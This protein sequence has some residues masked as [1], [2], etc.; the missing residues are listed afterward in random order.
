MES[1]SDFPRNWDFSAEPE[2]VG[3]YCEIREVAFPDG[4]RQLVELELDSGERVT[5]WLS[6]AA[7]RRNF[8]DELK[9]RARNGASDFE[10][11]ERI[12]IVRGASKRTS[13]NGFDYW[14]FT[15]EF[16]HAAK[17]SAADLLLGDE[18]QAG[19]ASQLSPD[20]DLPF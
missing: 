2:L 18:S 8:V 10:V 15:I 7:L 16:Q 9:A 20:D 4:S 19:D 1:N 3:H 6:A 17:R 13:A 11:G 14:P 5:L 12:K